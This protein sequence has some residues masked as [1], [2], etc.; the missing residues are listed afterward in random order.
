MT[1]LK[2]D[3]QQSHID[4]KIFPTKIKVQTEQVKLVNAL[5]HTY[6]GTRPNLHVI[7]TTQAIKPFGDFSIFM[8]FEF[9]NTLKNKT[10]KVRSTKKQQVQNKT[11]KRNML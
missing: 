5:H 1:S 8:V 3:L 9:F 11:C 10:Y 4:F 7:Y 2:I 6:E